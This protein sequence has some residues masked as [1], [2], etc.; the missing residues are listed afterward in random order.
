VIGRILP[1][2]NVRGLPPDESAGRP[3]QPLGAGRRATPAAAPLSREAGERFRALVLPHLDSAYAFARFLARDPT[4]AEDVVQEAFLKAYRGFEGFRGGDPRAWLF[5]IVRT[6]FISSQ[7]RKRDL[8][9]IDDG[10][11]IASEAETPEAALVRLGE[12]AGLRA[13]IESLPEPF[14]ETLVLRELE[15]LSYR[16]IAQLTSA[17]IGTVMSRLARARAMLAVALGVKDAQ[18]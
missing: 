6:T 12:V 18:P 8:A 1:F 2:R 9:D 7:R 3:D 5:A 11:E 10:P 4:L 15:E 17:P 16:D 14:R 13:A